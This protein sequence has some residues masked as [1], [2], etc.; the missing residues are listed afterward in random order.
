MPNRHDASAGE[1]VLAQECVQLAHQC[2]QR[3]EPDTVQSTREVLR[4]LGLGEAT[5][6]HDFALGLLR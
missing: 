2:R 3:V 6:D 1:V 5:L 4:E